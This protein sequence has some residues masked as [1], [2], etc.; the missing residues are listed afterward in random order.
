MHCYHFVVS[1]FCSANGSNH[2][3]A[4]I[5]APQMSV[6]HGRSVIFPEA[7]LF[8]TSFSSLRLLDFIHFN[9]FGKC[10]PYSCEQKSKQFRP[11]SPYLQGGEGL[12]KLFPSLSQN[13]ANESP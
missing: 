1:F 12:A 4:P 2:H 7:R 10:H 11:V 9:T 5:P 13:Q 6:A 8:A 3:K